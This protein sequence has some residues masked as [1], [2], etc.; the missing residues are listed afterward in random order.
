MLIPQIQYFTNDSWELI[1]GVDGELGWPLL[2]QA[3]YGNAKLYLL[4]VPENFT[5][6]YH[7]PVSVLNMIRSRLCK[8]LDLTLEGESKVSMFL[9]DNDTV[10]IHSFR[11][12]PTTV[13]LISN[14]LN[15][16]LDDLVSGAPINPVIT[17][18]VKFRS[19]VIV[20]ERSTFAIAVPAHSLRAFSLAPVSEK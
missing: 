11:D 7:L 12:E 15:L 4:V 3:D 19:M 10:V 5:D 8:G 17:E 18:A 2:H 14:D 6:L 9:Y 16:K 13:N 1:E 20:P